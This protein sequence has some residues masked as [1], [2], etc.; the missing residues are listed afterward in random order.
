MKKKW[1][2]RGAF[3]LIAV[4][5]VFTIGFTLLIELT[6]LN[7]AKL[8]GS[9]LPTE[10]Y[11]G[12]AS[13]YLTI[14]TP[15][16]TDLPFQDIP[17]NL[18][19]AL[20]ATEDHTYWH[21][22]SIDIKGIFRAMFVDLWTQRLAQGGSTIQ[23][24][25][26]KIVYL[27]DKKTFLRKIQQIALGVQ[28]N[29]SFTKQEILAMYLNRVYLGSGCIGVDQAAMRY[30]GI[31]LHT[32][33]NKLTLVQAALL[34]GLPQEPS[35]YDPLVH[36]G[37]ALT[38]RNQ[39]LD[40]LAKYGYLTSAQAATAKK[41]PLGLKP[42]AVPTQ[43]Q[44]THP[45]FYNFLL[46]YV[47]KNA[48]TMGITSATL[49]QGGLK[50]YTTIDPQVQSAIHEVFMSGNYQKDLPPFVNGKMTEGAALFVDPQ[51]GGIIGAAG[52]TKQGFETGGFD[53]A[54]AAMGSPGSSIKPLMEYGPAIE[55]G[56]WT[57]NSV[58]NNTP[59]DF[60]GY[61]PR[62]D[63]ANAPG[64]VSLAYALATSQN[65]ASTSLLQ[66]IGIN[67]GA[68][69]AA[70]AGIT[71]TSKDREHLDIAVGGLQNY[72]SPLEMA[73]AY[74]AF[75]NQGV[76]EQAHLITKIINAQGQLI[77]Q[78]RPAAKRLMSVS[79][80]QTMT[81]LM[82]NVVN[83]GT[84]Q[85]AQVS[86]WELAGKTGTVQY[87]ASQSG[88]HLNWIRN[89]W[90]DGYTTN[91]V[92]S[93]YLGFDEPNTTYHLTDIPYSPAYNCAVLFH[94]IVTLAEQGH[95]PQA[96]GS[97]ATSP[98][99]PVT[100]AITGLQGVWGT[101]SSAVQLNWQSSM[102]G[103]VNFVISR[104]VLAGAQPPGQTGSGGPGKGKG[105]GDK[106]G[107]PPASGSGPGQSSGGGVA[108]PPI[109][110]G[111]TANLAFLDPS[112]S[113]GITYLYSVQAVNP[114]TSQPVGA[115]VTVQVS[116]PAN[117]VIQP[118]TGG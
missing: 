88:S 70:N 28:I 13:H 25:L 41:Q 56:K 29:R 111:E 117:V 83:W 14:G 85:A 46:S 5:V 118:P 22:S 74:E 12:D 87:D 100:Q 71:V 113:P 72:V 106:G 32:E 26:A 99:Q 38:R 55:S 47:D 19:N 11:A 9:T 107:A 92:G 2:V 45:L 68:D 116:V 39:V 18:Q 50:I 17:K 8:V 59:H 36:P 64:Q 51:S 73:Q 110:L 65:I 63:E 62:N 81:Q 78:Y 49:L 95:A 37:A 54:I 112:A 57:A 44:D 35:G 90:F 1:L 75:D 114:S 89:G 101:N 77:Y 48:K 15:N 34:A 61:T 105:H 42:S 80:A 79:T 3:L 20:V 66:Q 7:Q 91:L 102:V 53:R 97:G 6:P 60:G 21:S 115:A 69:F 31:D 96:F 109:Q 58:L 93:I 43:P 33:G 16:T 30:F 104:E 82:E 67:T 84:G 23:E 94:D 40:N 98:Q 24:Q 76:Q 52:S 4:V 27:S 10:V 86:G 108:G 103:Q